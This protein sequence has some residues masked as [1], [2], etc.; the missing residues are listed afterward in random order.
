MMEAA[1]QLGSLATSISGLFGMS[2]NL[3]QAPGSLERRVNSPT[4]QRP[5]SPTSI[6]FIRSHPTWKV[7]SA[8]C[9]WVGRMPKKARVTACKRTPFSL[10]AVK[11]RGRSLMSTAKLF[12]KVRPYRQP[13]V[14]S[15][16]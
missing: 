4:M 10:Y 11:T 5:G 8:N 7:I 14:N 2:T 6:R 15:V 1:H 9:C 13:L 16:R 12:D 3:R